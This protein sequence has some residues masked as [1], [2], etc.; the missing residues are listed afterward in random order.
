LIDVNLHPDT[1]FQVLKVPADPDKIYLFFA[2]EDGSVNAQVA[3]D[4]LEE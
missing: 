2:N 4:I 1:N 3:V